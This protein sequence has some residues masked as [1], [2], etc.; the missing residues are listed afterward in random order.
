M[1]VVGHA[2]PRHGAFTDARVHLTD[3]SSLPDDA[4]YRSLFPAV[5][6]RKRNNIF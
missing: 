3:L 5:F 4:F 1:A 6:F 2:L